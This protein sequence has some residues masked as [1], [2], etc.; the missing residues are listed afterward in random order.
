MEKQAAKIAA[1][2]TASRK[3]RTREM[4]LC[5]LPGVSFLTHQVDHRLNNPVH[6]LLIR[7]LDCWFLGT[8]NPDPDT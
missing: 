7:N 3:G 5:S 2:H 4:T 1:W 8:V 6:A